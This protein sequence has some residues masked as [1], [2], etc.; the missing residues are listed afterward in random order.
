MTVAPSR[1]KSKIFLCPKVQ[2]FSPASEHVAE[3]R[4]A[5][6]RMAQKNFFSL[7]GFSE[8]GTGDISG[9]S[10][11]WA[12]QY[13]SRSAAALETFILSMLASI[14]SC[15]TSFRA[16]AILAVLL[17][18]IGPVCLL[19]LC[20]QFLSLLLW[21]P[22]ASSA[23]SVQPLALRRFSRYIQSLSALLCRFQKGRDGGVSVK[24]AAGEAGQ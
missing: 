10:L 18:A 2:K 22:A 3:E 16:C 11:A 15:S 24:H 7:N 9:S 23:L 6:Y 19:R 17:V 1:P 20:S 13:D 8:A 12:S 5:L 21:A 14:L 4:A